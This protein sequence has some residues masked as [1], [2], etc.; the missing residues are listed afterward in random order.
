MTQQIHFRAVIEVLGKPKEHVDSSLKGYVQNIKDSKKY[1][2]TK[3]QF[4]DL[5]KQQDS[6]LWAAFAELELKTDSIQHL[7]D[8]CFDYMP[9]L[10]EIIEPHK[11]ELNSTDISIFLN[12]LQAKLH[13]VDMLAKQLKMEN[14]LAGKSFNVLLNNYVT[15]L[16]QQHNLDSEQ[17]SKMT[18]VSKEILEDFLDHLIDEGKID[19]KEGIYFIKQQRDEAK[20]GRKRKKG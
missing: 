20:D 5:Q 15:F 6:E 3:E 16:L 7:I 10:I 12:D 17:L 13:G 9:S 8:F 4:A 18:G 1:T 14:T 11:L 2:I 19:L